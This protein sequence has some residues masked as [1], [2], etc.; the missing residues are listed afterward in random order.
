MAIVPDTRDPSVLDCARWWSMADQ[1]GQV[2]HET[3]EWA[4]DWHNKVKYQSYFATSIYFPF[5]LGGM[6]PGVLLLNS[7]GESCMID[8]ANMEED[9]KGMVRRPGWWRYDVFW[10]E[11]LAMT[12]VKDMIEQAHGGIHLGPAEAVLDEE[13]RRR[14]IDGNTWRKKYLPQPGSSHL[15][16]LWGML[17]DLHVATWTLYTTGLSW[18]AYRGIDVYIRQYAWGMPEPKQEAHWLVN[19]CEHVWWERPL[20]E[21]YDWYK[22]RVWESKGQKD[23]IF[24]WNLKEFARLMS[25]L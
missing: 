13:W 21:P 10:F 25:R 14:R 15:M 16:P 7:T 4:M 24:V 6:T 5:M 1:N 11:G 3:L 12:N 22:C 17:H 20:L 23:C 19:H 8:K 2:S 9:G 18:H